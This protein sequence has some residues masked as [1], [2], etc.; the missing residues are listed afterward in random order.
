VSK[1]LN[2]WLELQISIC[3]LFDCDYPYPW[4]KTMQWNR[5][6]LRCSGWFLCTSCK[7]VLSEYGLS[8][9]AKRSKRNKYTTCAFSYSPTNVH[10][11]FI[12]IFKTSSRSR[13][14]LAFFF[15]I[16]SPYRCCSQISS[17][18]NVI[19]LKNF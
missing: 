9:K 16:I 11:L 6:S 10:C 15:S 17:L 2:C 7:L 13:I 18:I 19:L 1:I 12:G 5:N 3:G 4:I 8:K 14:A